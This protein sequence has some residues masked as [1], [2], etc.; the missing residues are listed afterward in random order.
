MYVLFA[1]R[2]LWPLVSFQ[3]MAGPLGCFISFP[4]GRS[5]ALDPLDDAGLDA[6]WRPNMDPNLADLN[7]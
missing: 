5:C 2:R 7:T 1:A 6:G 3:F 4:D